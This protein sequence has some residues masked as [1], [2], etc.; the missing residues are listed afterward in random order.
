M[1]INFVVKYG[2]A[3]FETSFCVIFSRRQSR[4][5]SPQRET[6]IFLR[7]I[8]DGHFAIVFVDVHPNPREVVAD[9][10]R[11]RDHPEAIFSHARDRQV[12]F[13]AAFRIQ[14]LSVDRAANGLI[15]VAVC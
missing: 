2:C 4:L 7:D 13:D 3:S 6:G 15:H 12:R 8:A 1:W 10:A 11:T 5:R 9:E 14:E